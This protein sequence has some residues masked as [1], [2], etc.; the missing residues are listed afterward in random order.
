MNRKRLLHIITSLSTGGAERA[1][2]NLLA[3]GLAEQF[4][5]M[6]V[7]LRDEGTFGEAIVELGVPVYSLGIGR[8]TPSLKA[9]LGLR[10]I[11]RNFKPH[12]I[13]GWMYHGNLAASAGALIAD[14]KP[15]VVWNIRHS[16]YRLEDEKRLTQFTI[17]AGRFFSSRPATILYNSQVSR[18]QHEAFGFANE[19][20]RVIPNGFD[21]DR[22]S[23]STTGGSKVRRSL[24]IPD[25]ATVVGH[26][27]RFHPMKDHAGFLRA[28]VKVATSVTGVHFLVAGRQ[29]DLSN[30]ALSGI[31]PEVLISRFHFVGERKDVP[32]LMSAMDVFC[33]SSRGEAFPNVLGEAM[34]C[35]VPCVA[36]DVGDSAYILGETGVVVAPHDVEALA[37]A[38]VHFISM[39]DEERRALGMLARAR[40]TDNFS[41][42][43]V[44][45]RYGKLYGHYLTMASTLKV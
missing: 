15:V 30:P 16:L 10:A 29:V 31:V 11:V 17:R 28:A 19:N 4:D 1:L 6:V 5:C 45:E 39:P 27:A 42:P 37:R 44:V 35:G 2:Y 22:W 18:Q 9:L 40:V 25:N 33:S 14:P 3:G 8:G 41:L 7:S 12:I 36:T 32:D 38:L 43:V 24:G 13:Q 26:V 23:P 34:A 20:G 21:I